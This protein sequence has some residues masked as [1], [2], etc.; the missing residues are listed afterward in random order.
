V[1][2]VD[3][4]LKCHFSQSLMTAQSGLGMDVPDFLEVMKKHFM[5]SLVW[6]LGGNIS[7][8]EGKEKFSDFIRDT[9]HFV[10]F[11][12]DAHHLEQFQCQLRLHHRHVF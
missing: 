12:S 1:A 6:S 4:F 7:G 5:F 3:E 9:F 8:P 11:M 2:I 10:R